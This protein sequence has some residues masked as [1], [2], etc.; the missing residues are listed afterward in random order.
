M[1]AHLSFH[2][3]VERNWQMD[4][5][6]KIVADD[7]EMKTTNLSAKYTLMFRSIHLCC[8]YSSSTNM[9]LKLS[10]H[11]WLHHIYTEN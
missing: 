3:G 5:E 10:C 8:R 7:S 1:L 4:N 2:I 11:I 6:K 9:R